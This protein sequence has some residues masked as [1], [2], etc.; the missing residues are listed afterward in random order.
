VFCSDV[1]IYMRD[2][3]LDSGRGPAPSGV[4][5]PFDSASLVWWWQSEDIVVDAPPFATTSPVTDHVTLANEIV[6]ENAR[7]GQTNRFYVQVHNRGPFKATNVRVRAFFANAS[8]VLPTLPGDF[9]SGMNPFDGDPTAVDWAPIGP[10]QP[11][12]DIEPGDT[13][14]VSWDW[15][16][17][18]AAAEHSCLLAL[19]TCTEDS[20]N[21]MGVLDPGQLI[22]DNNNVTLK[23]LTIV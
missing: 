8:A 22:N 10:T 21:A 7:R 11:A 14:I 20:L 23:N 9:W 17:P 1:D 16:V 19:A 2:N 12:G 5:H 6:H 18:P 3:I 15:P 13:A 4:P